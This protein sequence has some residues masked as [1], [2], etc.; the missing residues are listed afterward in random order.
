MKKIPLNVLEE[1]EKYTSNKTLNHAFLRLKSLIDELNRRDLSKEVISEINQQIDELNSFTGSDKNTRQQILKTQQ[2]IISVLR[3]KMKIV[4]KNFYRNIW[5]A[6]GIGAF[7]LPM[8]VAYGLL[9]DNMAFMAIGLPLGLP[10]GLGI[11]I[12]MDKKAAKEG[13]QL[14]FDV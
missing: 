13:R 10:I 2:K 8:G 5:M 7:G 4:P 3:E 14:D 9:L 6:L 1:K 11:G 12:A